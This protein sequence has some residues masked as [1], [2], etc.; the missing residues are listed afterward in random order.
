[1]L[2]IDAATEGSTV[3]AYLRLDPCDAVRTAAPD[4]TVLLVFLQ[5]TTLECRRKLQVCRAI[6]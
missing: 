3:G 1:M 4:D 2:K 5:S 6:L